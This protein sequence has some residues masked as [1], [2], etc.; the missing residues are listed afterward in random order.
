[1]DSCSKFPRRVRI[2]GGE[3]GAVARALHHEAKSSS[4]PAVKGNVFF[5]TTERKSM[6]TKTSLLKR[7]AQ[8]AVVAL[9]G[10]LLATVA[11][12]AAQAASNPNVT[13]S[14]TC[15]MREGV[16]GLINASFTGAGTGAAKVRAIGTSYSLA[17]GFTSYAVAAGFTGVPL[18][19]GVISDTT[20]STL[21]IPL[22][23]DTVTGV[24]TL[25]YTV[26][27]DVNGTD[28]TT[29]GAT[30]SQSTS[31]TC[32]NG[33][34]P[35][36]FTLSASS[37]TKVAG[38]TATFTVTPVGAAGVTTILRPGTESFTVTATPTLGK[39]NLVAGTLQTTTGPNTIG[40]AGLSDTGTV[41]TGTVS[42]TRASFGAGDTTKSRYYGIVG[43][44]G[45]AGAA[46]GTANV[47]S[48]GN[49]PSAF[50]GS[51]TGGDTSKA[52]IN[53]DAT[54]ANAAPTYRQGTG[55]HVGE[56]N[57]A[58]PANTES[59][60]AT[61]AF[62][63]NVRAES[64]TTTSVVVAGAGLIANSV[65]ST[66]TL[67]TSPAVYGTS[68]G[69][70]S[71]SAIVVP[72]FGIVKSGTGW[73][74]TASTVGLV[75]PTPATTSGA[76]T[77]SATL[78]VST[79]RT[80]IPLTVQ[81]SQAGT[82]SYTVAAVTGYTLPSGVTAGTYTYTSPTGVE[83]Q[84]A[85]TWTVSALAD[86]QRFTVTWA[87]AANSTMV[88]TFVVA[89]P[90]VG[91]SDG[92][93]TLR[94]TASS[95][96]FDIGAT[97]TNVAT[98]RD[99]YGSLVSGANVQF[100]V[101]G[102]NIKSAT[103]V[104]TGAAGTASY[105]WTDAST[106]TTSLTDTLSVSVTHG[107]SG[108][109]ATASTAYTNVQT[110]L[111]ASAITVATNAAS[112]GVAA[113]GAVTLTIK[114]TNSSGAGLSGYPVAISVDSKSFATA[115]GDL[116]ANAYTD[117]NGDASA[118]IWA[119]TAGSSTVTVTSAG[120]TASVSYTVIAGSHRTIVLDAATATMAPNET[121]RVTATVKDS[122]GNLADGV[123]VAI[124]YTGTSGRVVSVNGVTS[125]SCTTSAAVGSEGTCVIELG[126][127]V[128]G[129]GTLTVTVTGGDSSSNVLNDGSSRPARVLTASTAVTIA[130]TSAAV[131]AS[132]AAT[133][134]AEAATDA[135]AEAIDAANAA[136]DAAN[137]AA[138][139]ADAATV[140]AEEARD[141]A[142]AATAA[143]EE[144]AT[145]VATLM[146]AL[147]AQIT[148]LANTVAKIAKK[149]KA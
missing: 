70:G 94:D 87:D 128:A 10:G 105:S 95:K 1:M 36:A 34:A 11:T 145:Q 82:F 108:S 60:T 147:K 131:T 77:A 25:Q 51:T 112:T 91:S 32:T 119:K 27:I 130:G 5:T 79:A 90:K 3:C 38:D 121:K 99:Q 21:V 69:V 6:S 72:G 44:N 133:A 97:I 67:T 35:T 78:N 46:I 14:A 89:A 43:R 86:G 33:G 40:G 75:A 96:K 107:N 37:S 49:M 2:H 8:T 29:P 129:T 136:T 7:I 41:T 124:A 139:A 80:T 65:S 18:T 138:E 126:A 85:L 101:A 73:S 83:T 22:A 47:T 140:A 88:A 13:I 118:T 103:S 63:I 48:S 16:G 117:S 110:A 122:F 58:T 106:S 125:S 100:S 54:M 120:K 81:M 4:L 26:W 57:S 59:A 15:V 12:P 31:V 135:A 111:A 102:R 148:T 116:T 71:S 55:N 50:S 28:T 24:Q 127:D 93:I 20:S 84:A 23:S 146:A 52:V 142:D 66:Y 113:N 143:V 76:A 30:S 92:S 149:V 45:S 56:F 144:L 61:G 123:S 132:N 53:M 115:T 68:Y 134:A 109:F 64:N 19:S 9:F 114:V 62:T 42:V 104:A 137:L 141:A 98:V 74:A 39:A 17:S